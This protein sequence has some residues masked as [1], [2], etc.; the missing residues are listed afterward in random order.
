MWRVTNKIYGQHV[1]VQENCWISIGN[2][3]ECEIFV[4]DL[5]KNTLLCQI[6]F[7]ALFAFQVAENQTHVFFKNGHFYAHGLSFGFDFLGHSLIS[8]SV[9]PDEKDLS[10]LFKSSDFLNTLNHVHE[11]MSEN[12]SSSLECETELVLQRACVFLSRSFW[13]ES[14]VFEEKSR[15]A[16]KEVV[17]AIWAQIFDYGILALPLADN[18]ISE[19][20]VNSV[21]AI[22]FEREGK[23]V[24]SGL[25]FIS[26]KEIFSLIE[27]MVHAS[28]R[29]IDESRPYCD[30]RLQDGSRIHAIIPPVSIN[31][32]CLTVRKFSRQPLTPE[33]LIKNGA[34]PEFVLEKLKFLVQDKKN[35]L[36]SGGTGS[37]KTTLLNCLSAFIPEYE[38]IITIEDSAELKLQQQHVVRLECRNENIENKG[39]ISI[40]D[41][42]KN[43][44]RMRPDRIIIGE[45]RGAEALDML[46]AMNTGH[47]GSMTTIHANSP[48]DAL[49]RLETLVL[50]SEIDLPS[51]AIREQICSAI[52]YIV[53]QSRLSNG[54][55][56]ITQVCAVVGLCSQTNSFILNEIYRFSGPKE[57]E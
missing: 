16:F 46:Q 20:M 36:I 10:L 24:L 6:I 40:R 19:V 12:N 23:I 44:L 28:G 18:S 1:E 47:D 51:K 25:S 4:E 2:L 45:C 41:L 43:T 37:G 21:D 57:V 3:E 8:E 9:K 38:R 56:C 26:Q 27:R 55:R 48:V 7:N 15:Q 39:Q 11:N 33:I 54:Q 30:A 52:Q 53:H 31:G 32:P 5:P 42:L 29:R 49:R 14:G 13:N 34:F 50:F 22:Y 17:W 35:I